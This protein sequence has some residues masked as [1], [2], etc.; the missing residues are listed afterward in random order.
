MVFMAVMGSVKRYGNSA[1]QS[2]TIFH[3]RSVIRVR[4]VPFQQREFRA[5]ERGALPVTE[6]M[7]DLILLF[8]ACGHQLLHREL[9][10]GV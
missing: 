2:L 6:D 8:Y 9:G 5:V 10:A 4:S 1:Q 7:C 3:H